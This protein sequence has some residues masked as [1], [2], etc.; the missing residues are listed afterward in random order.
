MEP[1]N[2]IRNITAFNDTQTNIFTTTA[3]SE[4]ALHLFVD[5]SGSISFNAE[6]L[7]TAV[8]ALVKGS[9]AEGKFE[10]PRPS[11][12]TA[13]IQT[14]MDAR[15]Q[16]DKDTYVLFTDGGENS[17]NG[18][19]DFG[20]NEDNTRR[21][22]NWNQ[23][24]SDVIKFGLLAE[25]LQTQGVKICLLGIG[26]EAKPMLDQMVGMKNV[27]AAYIEHSLCTKEVFGVVKTLRNIAKRNSSGFSSTRHGVQHVLLMSDSAD[28]TETIKSL[29]DTE[30]HEVEAAISHV[31]IADGAVLCASDIKMKID[32]VLELYN[33]EDNIDIKSIDHD[34]KC[35][36]LFGM[37]LMCGQIT[38]AASVASKHSMV[39]V[40]PPACL[41]YV[42]HCNAIFSRMAKSGILKKEESTPKEGLSLEIDGVMRK[43]P[44]DCAQY[45]CAYDARIV[46]IVANDATYCTPPPANKKQ[47]NAA[48]DTPRPPNKKQKIAAN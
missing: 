23:H 30:I 35:G 29:S 33:K 43:F 16:G 45:S 39:F 25:W 41:G 38:P 19:L 34:I 18:V 27:Y 22:V 17:Y 12:S 47:K 3:D 32:S 5:H 24:D 1:P 26:P 8:A 36:I 4:D 9:N 2:F 6:L 7:R 46:D 20:L 42:K 10:I 44:K 48:N 15:A 37:R 14:V 11:G 21:L 13:I 28:V 40:P 31:R